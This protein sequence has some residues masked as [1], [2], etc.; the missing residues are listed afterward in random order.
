MAA[1][2]E[3]QNEEVGFWA[4]I[5]DHV[6]HPWVLSTQI[7]LRFVFGNQEHMQEHIT[8]AHYGRPEA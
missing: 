8:T 6:I 7:H 2:E 4:D 3:E 5:I 1:G